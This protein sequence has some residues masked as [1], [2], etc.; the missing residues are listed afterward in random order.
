MV[1]RIVSI[2]RASMIG[3]L[4]E[5]GAVALKVTKGVQIFIGIRG[6]S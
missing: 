4:K 5:E 6:R 3:S 2:F 1:I